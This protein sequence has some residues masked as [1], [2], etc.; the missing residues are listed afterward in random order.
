MN[1][2]EAVPPPCL[3]GK[4]KFPPQCRSILPKKPDKS[5]RLFTDPMPIDLN[6]IELF[7]GGCEAAHLWT[8]YNHLVAGI[9][10]RARL[11]PHSAI[12]GHWKVLDDDQNC[13][14]LAGRFGRIRRA[15]DGSP[16]DSPQ[17]GRGFGDFSPGLSR[18]RIAEQ[19]EEE[20]R[21]VLKISW[22]QPERFRPKTKNPSQ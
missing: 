21:I 9:S 10:Q 15:S 11:L 2:L 8:D 14:S 22:S 18:N 19:I 1:Y 13:L 17:G 12:Q 20:K 6:T 5:S 4:A 3:P 7:L 16:I